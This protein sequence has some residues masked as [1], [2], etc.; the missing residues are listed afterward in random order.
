MAVVVEQVKVLSSK[1]VSIQTIFAGLPEWL[2]AKLWR[3]YMI[4][5]RAADNELS[6]L[7]NPKMPERLHT[8]P[9]LNIH[10][11]S[12]PEWLQA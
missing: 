10:N 5:R 6:I 11:P 8:H 3:P 7:H 9:G 1:D 2:Q 12:L 4:L